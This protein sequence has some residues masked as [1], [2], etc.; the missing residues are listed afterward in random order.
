V[1][2]ESRDGGGSL[3]VLSL[4]AADIAAL[5]EDRTGPPSL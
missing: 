2:C 1:R 4:P 3:F 5:Q